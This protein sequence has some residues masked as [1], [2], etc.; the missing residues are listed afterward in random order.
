M[1]CFE[2]G[3]RK[4]AIIDSGTTLAYL[5]EIVYVPLVSKILSEQPDLKVHTVLD[6]YTCFQYNGRLGEQ[7]S[8]SDWT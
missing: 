2:S 1:K 5:P 6:E 4:G 7:G 3:D 8:H